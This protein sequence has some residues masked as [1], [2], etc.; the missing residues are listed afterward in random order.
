MCKCFIRGLKSEIEQRNLRV[1]DTVADAL[2]IERE[3]QQITDLR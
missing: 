2:K 3:L 1:Q